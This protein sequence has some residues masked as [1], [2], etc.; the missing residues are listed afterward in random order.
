MDLISLLPQH[1]APYQCSTDKISSHFVSLKWRWPIGAGNPLAIRPI[2]RPS[3]KNI[4]HRQWRSAPRSEP[5]AALRDSGHDRHSA[6]RPGTLTHYTPTGKY[7]KIETKFKTLNIENSFLIQ[8]CPTPALLPDGSVSRISRDRFIFSR[9]DFFAHL[10]KN[11]NIRLWFAFQKL[12]SSHLQI[13][14]TLRPITFSYV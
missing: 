10:L 3:T 13:N 7:C 8:M 5:T 11:N 2:P 1:S 6:L 14:V 4:T 12:K 9:R